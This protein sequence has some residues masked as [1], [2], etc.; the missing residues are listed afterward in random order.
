MPSL[1]AIASIRRHPSLLAVLVFVGIATAF[2]QRALLPG[3]TLL[4][5]DLIQAIAPWDHLDLGPLANPLISDPFYSFYTRRHFLTASI[6]SGQLPLWNPYVLSGTPTIANPN[7][8]P[9]YVPNL[10]VALFLP[11]H[12]ALSWLAWGHLIVTGWLMYGFLR[13]QRLAWLAS[14][15]GGG[16]W[17]LNGYLV[18]WLENPHRLSTLAWLPGIFWAYECAASERRLDYAAVG[19]VLLG[20]SILG[21]Q[22]QFIFAAGL[23]LGVYVLATMGW[24]AY[25]KRRWSLWP[26]LPLFTIGIIGLGIGAVTLLPAGEFASFSQRL[27]FTADTIVGTRWPWQHLV[28]LIA[29]DFYGN[30]VNAEKYW[31]PFNY[32]ELTAYFGVV[33]LLL[34]LTA[35]F[36]AR[37][38]R[39]LFSALVVTA[40]TLAIIFGSPLVR[41]LFL[42]PG[43]QFIALNRLLFLVPLCG[44]WL[45]ALGLDG[46]LSNPAG[47]KR[48]LVI[49]LLAI[50]VIVI[51]TI[52]SQEVTVATHPGT[53]TDLARSGLLLLGTVG[54]MLVLF[55]RPQ[56][57]G[58]LLLLLALVDLW[59]WGW[60]FNPVTSTAYLYPE[61]EVTEFLQQDSS[62]FRVLPLQSGKLLFGPNV[63]TIFGL[64]TIG[65]YTPLIQSNYYDFYKAISDQLDF[66]WLLDS[67]NKLAMSEFDP[68]VSLLN[69]KYVLSPE[70][71]STN[72]LLQVEQAGC[73]TAVPLTKEWRT[74]TFTATSAGLNRVDILFGPGEATAGDT[75]TFHLWR[76]RFQGELVA[77]AE[78]QAPG[79]ETP[80]Y[81]PVFFKP[82][83]DAEGQSFVW[84]VRGSGTTAICATGPDVDLSFAAYGTRLVSLGMKDDIW[85]YENPNTLPRAYLV[86]HAEVS[87][88]ENLLEEL[89]SPDFNY[90]HSVRLTSPLPEEQEAQLAKRPIR[91]QGQVQIVEYG[92]H[93]VSLAVSTSRPGILVLADAHYPGWQAT[94]NGVRAEVLKVNGVVR[95]IFL[96]TGTH[97]VTF[98]F[99]PTSL[100]LGLGLAGL[101][102]VVATGIVAGSAY[103]RRAAEREGDGKGNSYDY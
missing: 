71:L 11:A 50:A 27:R 52:W 45:A 18:V 89:D 44:A 19:G 64:E 96:P 1:K 68:D 15:L 57:G 90:Y 88:M 32:A 25:E 31:G 78:I 101:A 62:Q 70:S 33:S 99:R 48:S 43:A 93:E 12:H 98:Q 80:T 5:L 9:F 17:M 86:H 13:R 66:S 79:T 41:L 73:D 100:Y 81:H 56:I 36:V 59:Q 3:Y 8:Q 16:I 2:L 22:M 91:A 24:D 4:P 85:L 10:I 53:Y 67:P 30:P 29:P 97:E 61:N 46:W 58:A 76:D 40:L 60:D 77:E 92:L 51:I 94:V 83:A 95:G 34:A 37:S 42:F 102:I 55:R 26:L 14:V 39:F 54:L 87:S 7:F 63:L 65:G 84:G 35:P 28:T 82:I 47:Q 72:P 38:R 74:E 6:E 21:G 23:L 20:L 75:V 49:A 103:R 69:V